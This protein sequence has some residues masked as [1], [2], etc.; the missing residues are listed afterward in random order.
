ML[1]IAVCGDG[2]VAHSIAA[3]CAGRGHAVRV[4]AA[5]AQQWNGRLSTT[6]ADGSRFV[7]RIAFATADPAAALDGA[8][9]VF[10]CE[11]HAEVEPTLRRIAPHIAVD[12]LVGAVPGFGGFGPLA[13]RW[14]PQSACL[15]GTQRIPFV[16][17]RCKYGR[18]VGIGGVRRQTF[19]AT[20]PAEQARPVA[21]LLAQVLGVR[22]VPVS[23]Y[24]SVE[25]SPSNSIVNPARLYALFGAD[26][27]GRVPAGGE[28]FTG[29]D[30]PSSRMLLALDRELQQA[31]ACVPRDTSF[32]A[33]IL[34]QYDANDAETLT[35]RFRALRALAGRRIPVCGA[36]IDP[37]CS[38]LGEDID[39]GLTLLRDALHLAGAQ[40]PLMD[41]ILG[42]RRSLLT[43]GERRRWARRPR[44]VA[45]FES[46]EALAQALD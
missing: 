21:E 2:A 15:F 36:G 26:A 11:P 6:L 4:L 8:D 13:R 41:D 32:V 27:Q 39:I 19:I 22:T 45:A 28:F 31:R 35:L 18:S 34:M 7:A 38:Y 16:V 44:V 1:R 24:F 23:H 12:A 3:V 40:T 5:N 14:L 20:M 42:W 10:V 37:D 46:I 30:L 17:R 43:A 33:P 9:I 25:L 29:W